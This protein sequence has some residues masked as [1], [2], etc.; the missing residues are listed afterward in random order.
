[1]PPEAS[2]TSRPATIST[3]WRIAA[4]SMLS[5]SS[6]VGDAGVEHLAQLL[7]RIDLDLDLDQMSGAGARALQHGADAAGDRDVVVLDQHG[8]VEPEA[9]VE[10]AAAAHRVFLQRAQAGRGLARAADARVACRAMRRTNSCV[11]VATPDRWPRKLSAARSAASTARAGPVDCHQRG[12]GRDLVAVA[13]VRGDL[14]LGRELA[15]CG[16]GQRQPG[17][18]AGLARDHDGARR[19]CLQEW[20]RSR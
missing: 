7:E 15:E 4:A 20:W 12:L 16:G 10:P 14:D 9:M 13:R 8:V 2:S 1:M 3:A 19:A 17:D 18:H 5:S 6:D 11:A